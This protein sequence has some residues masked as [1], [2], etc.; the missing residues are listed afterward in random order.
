MFHLFFCLDAKESKNQ[1]FIK[2]QCI[3]TSGFCH[4]TQAVHHKVDPETEG[5][6]SWFTSALL[7]ISLVHKTLLELLLKFYYVGLYVFRIVQAAK[8]YSSY[9][10]TLVKGFS[11][12]IFTFFVAHANSNKLIYLNF[13]MIKCKNSRQRERTGSQVQIRND[14]SLFK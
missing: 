6:S 1:D 2:F 13:L 12:F 14:Y 7:E 10:W 4:A 11:L 3:S 9:A 5:I 8:L